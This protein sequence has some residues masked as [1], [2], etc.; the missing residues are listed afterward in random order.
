MTTV[1]EENTL[2]AGEWGVFVALAAQDI[3]RE[4]GEAAANRVATSL[5]NHKADAIG[6]A[7]D[8]LHTTRAVLERTLGEVDEA[9]RA[10]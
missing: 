2:E 4:L 5:R 1:E 7:I 3:R 6:A 9:R 8:Q 10:H